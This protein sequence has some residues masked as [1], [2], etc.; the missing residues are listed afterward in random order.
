MQRAEVLLWTRRRTVLV[1]QA[2]VRGVNW[3]VWQQLM[4]EFVYRGA[5]D[6]A[7]DRFNDL[8]AARRLRRVD[9]RR[10]SHVVEV[11]GPPAA[12]PADHP[13]LA[14]NRNLPRS[15]P[16]IEQVLHDLHSVSRVA[17]IGQD[18]VQAL[19]RGR[20]LGACDGLDNREV[21]WSDGAR[22]DR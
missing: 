20:D 21:P 7:T 1:A 8:A 2:I 18:N 14:G 9:D 6:A 16:L 17:P 10:A 12:K 11:H 3:R 5:A 4:R 19:K 15:Y 22:E 13:R